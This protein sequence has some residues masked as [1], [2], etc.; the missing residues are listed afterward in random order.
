MR[1]DLAGTPEFTG[2][3]GSLRRSGGMMSWAALL[4]EI[5][6][7]TISVAAYDRLNELNEKNAQRIL[8]LEQQLEDKADVA[9]KALR[10]AWQLGQ[11][12]WQQADSEYTS[13][14]RKADETQAKFQ[15]LVDETRAAI[16]SDVTPKTDRLTG[17]A[18]LFAPGPG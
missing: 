14:H 16:L 18:R 5:D 4:Q 7:E 1:C 13:Q 8:D 15:T 11:T 3:R 17:L 2:L 6:M 12:Y 10:K 9:S